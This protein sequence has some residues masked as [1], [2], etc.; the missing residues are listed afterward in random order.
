MNMIMSNL[1]RL[2]MHCNK[3]LRIRHHIFTEK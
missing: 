2:L 3:L 1:V